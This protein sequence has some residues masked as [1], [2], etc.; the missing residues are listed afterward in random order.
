MCEMRKTRELSLRE[1]GRN[2][3]IY[4]QYYLIG[5][6]EKQVSVMSIVAKA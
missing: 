5:G 3:K 1:S 4:H 6:G 2:K